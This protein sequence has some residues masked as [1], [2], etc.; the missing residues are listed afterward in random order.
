[1]R[2][3]EIYRHDGFYAAPQSGELEPKYVLVLAVMR[4]GDIVYRLLTSRQHGRPEVPPCFH[5]DPYPGFYLG[6]PGGPLGSKTWLDLRRQGDYDG[7]SFAMRLGEGRITYVLRLP[8]PLLCDA[9]ECAAAAD[10]T[11]HAQERA[12]RDGLAA[13]R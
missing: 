4:G 6:V 2:P 7:D 9:L 8:N 10:D 12:M 13:L 11:T 1:M 3:G 5:G